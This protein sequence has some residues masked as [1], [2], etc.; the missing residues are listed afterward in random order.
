MHAVSRTDCSSYFQKYFTFCTGE[1]I[2]IFTAPA[3]TGSAFPSILSAFLTRMLPFRQPVEES[4]ARHPQEVR[5]HQESQRPLRRVGRGRREDRRAVRAVLLG[6]DRR[7]RDGRGRRRDEQDDGARVVEGPRRGPPLHRLAWV[8]CECVRAH[9]ECAREQTAD[10]C[11][12]DPN[13]IKVN[14][15]LK[16]QFGSHM[17]GMFQVDMKDFKTPKTVRRRL[18]RGMRA[19]FSPRTCRSSP[20]GN[21]LVC[22]YVSVSSSHLI[23]L[24]RLQRPPACG[25]WLPLQ[26]ARLAVLLLLLLGRHHALRKCTILR[27]GMHSRRR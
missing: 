7:L 26:V 16:L 3:I 6:L 17:D 12:V 10:V 5:E 25:G 15:T 8:H 4:R 27:V 23:A 1:G 21:L 9:T 18:S 13:V 19:S 2:K 24:R 11:A 20:E 14:N 22:P